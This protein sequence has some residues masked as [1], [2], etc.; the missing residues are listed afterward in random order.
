MLYNGFQFL[1]VGYGDVVPSTYCGRGIAVLTGL[2]VNY[3]IINFRHFIPSKRD[4]TPFCHLNRIFYTNFYQ[5]TFLT[6]D[7]INIT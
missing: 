5:L 6:L 7:S 1:S 4:L 2:M 3:I